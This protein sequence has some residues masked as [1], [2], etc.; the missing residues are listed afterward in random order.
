LKL[1]NKLIHIVGGGINQIPL[2]K[3]AKDM[4]LRVLLTDMYANPPAKRYSDFFE[5]VNVTDKE[6]TLETSKSYGI[7]AIATD[8]TD[9]A[10]ATVAYI[11]ETLKLPGIGYETALKFTNKHIMRNELRNKIS[12]TPQ[13]IYFDN[14]KEIKKQINSLTPPYVIKPVNS[15]GSKGVYILNLYDEEKII[16]SF[17]ESN[18]AG[19]LIEEYIDGEEVAVESYTSEGKSYILAVSRKEHYDS[20]DCIDKSVKFFA[21]F[22]TSLEQLLIT[23]NAKIIEALGL[24]NGICHAEFKL[25]GNK[26]YLMEIAVR[27]AGGNINSLI[28]PYLTGFDSLRSIVL[29]AFGIYE[30]PNIDD[31]KNNT[32]ILEFFDYNAGKIKD[33]NIEQSVITENCDFFTL[34]INPGDTIQPIK[35]SRDRKGYFIICD[36]DKENVMAKAQLVKNSIYLKYES[37]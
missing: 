33:I 20:N 12:S 14:I 7:D 36:K 2:V 17:N 21:D 35:D 34:D 22:D 3:K 18:G 26:P 16:S 24:S 6:K 8:Q 37:I 1:N 11:A 29:N 10:V 5:Q 28:I 30:A 25:R 23:E 4:G 32:A 15:Q 13:Y 9:V 19:V 31:Y 27:G